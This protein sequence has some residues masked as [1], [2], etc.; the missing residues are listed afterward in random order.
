MGV[1]MLLFDA[2]KLAGV[3]LRFPNGRS[4][5]QHSKEAFTYVRPHNIYTP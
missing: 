4:W 5:Q 2:L 3:E 1:N